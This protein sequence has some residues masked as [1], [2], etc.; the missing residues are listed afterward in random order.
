[1]GSEQFCH[2]YYI[3]NLII[4]ETDKLKGEPLVVVPSP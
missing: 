4:I 2:D 1:M 3:E